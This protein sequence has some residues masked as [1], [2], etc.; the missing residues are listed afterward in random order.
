MP[1]NLDDDEIAVW[2]SLVNALKT[3]L[4]KDD[5]NR[6]SELAKVEALLAQSFRAAKK[7]STVQG[8]PNPAHSHV[9]KYL[10]VRDKL[11]K[12]FT[13]RPPRPASSITALETLDSLL[14][15]TEAPN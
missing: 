9:E 3:V 11:L 7:G 4:F 5:G 1:A 2:T 12:A 8:R 14:S 6:L 13:S 15:R 10:R